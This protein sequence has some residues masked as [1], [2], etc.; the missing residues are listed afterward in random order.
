MVS[1][2]IPLSETPLVVLVIVIVG[3]VVST[4]N[5]LLAPREP[6]APGLAKVRVASLD[7]ASLIVPE[8][9]AKELEST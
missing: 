4:T 1:F 6:A 9:S 5:A 3:G 7:A 2:V 8:F